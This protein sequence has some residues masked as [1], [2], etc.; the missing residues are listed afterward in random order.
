MWR[1][2]TVYAKGLREKGSFIRNVSIASSW[3][4]AIIISQ[5]ILSPITT[6]LYDPS[7]YGV[8]A[9]F[10]SV[11]GN[12][13]IFS[14]LKYSDTIVLAENRINRNNAVALSFFLLLLTC[15]I[16][17]F[18]MLGIDVTNP[19][20]FGQSTTFFIYLIPIG[21]LLGGSFEILVAT[22][23]RRKKFV[24]NGVAGFLAGTSARFYNILHA[25]ALTPNAIGMILGELL[26][27]IFGIISSLLSFKKFGLAVRNAVA[28]ISWHVMKTIAIKHKAFPLY[29]LPSSALL[30]FSGQL[31]VYIFKL[32][33]STAVV[34]A[35]ALANSM[36]EIF[37]RLIP[38]ALSPVFLQKASELK[39]VS[40]EHLA[41]RVFR[42]FK[43]MTLLSTI[44][45]SGIAIAGEQVFPL[46]FGEKWVVA[47]VFASMLC[48]HY[49]LN[50]VAIALSEVYNVLGRQRLLFA[51][52]MVNLA[53]KV[54]GVVAIMYFQVSPVRA[55]LIYSAV[56]G[57]G[58]ML[59]VFCVF[60]ILKHRLIK[61]IAIT[62]LS[63][64]TI[65]I[66]LSLRGV[67]NIVWTK[68]LDATFNY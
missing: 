11:V 39:N 65:I 43:L 5:F 59:F 49:S 9:V 51:A 22:N 42:L 45:F 17:F 6:R 38:Y 48:I 25:L 68:F 13:L 36:L 1:N 63:L 2:V 26:G 8:F 55:V 64:I 46:F 27:K 58:A 15:C 67:F 50:F 14:T 4:I 66:A 41:D 57:L 60:V 52:S 30:F 33:Y 31:P 3:N 62:T 56:S 29:F 40:V 53:M 18:V 35:Y 61:A 21:V 12:I 16:S 23:V 37:N 10:N 28:S 32:Q 20:F 54:V 34:G 19:E 24:N 44:I 47:G 7:E